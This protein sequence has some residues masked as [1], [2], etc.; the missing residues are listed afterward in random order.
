MG[1]VCH[2]CYSTA[3]LNRTTNLE[4]TEELLGQAMA[5][6]ADLLEL[7]IKVQGGNWHVE[8]DDVGGT[9]GAFLSDVLDLPLVKTAISPSTSRSKNATRPK[10]NSLS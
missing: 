5:D 7:D 1:I 2:N 10:G 9:H 3:S 4:Q 8:H 6:G